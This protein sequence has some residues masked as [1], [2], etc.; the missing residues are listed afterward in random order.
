MK[1][2]IALALVS[3]VLV[4]CT[5]KE[6]PP[7][8]GNNTAAGVSVPES[9]TSAV[10]PSPADI[11]TDVNVSVPESSVSAVKPSP[12]DIAKEI[13]AKVPLS[14]QAVTQ[15]DISDFGFK[16]G[17]VKDFSYTVCG[18]GA[19]PDKLL[20]VEFETADDAKEGKK[21]ID[22]FLEQDKKSWKDYA[23]NEMYKFDDA[24]VTV[25]DNIMFYAVTP[26][27]STVKEITDKY[28]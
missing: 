22:D 13:L 2:V 14:G 11:A 20:I 7:T 4:S 26:D 9:I 6:T 24:F 23:P 12:A 21:I 18:T 3:A 16:E 27:N 17:T 1:K 25:K 8:E 28:K 10:K 15:D 5:K 19:Y